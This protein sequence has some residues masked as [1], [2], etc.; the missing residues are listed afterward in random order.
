MTTITQFIRYGIVGL[1]SNGLLYLAYL[2]LTTVGMGPKLAMS[3]LYALGVAQTFFF[4]KSWTFR[5][6][7]LY[8]PTFV[9]YCS[10]Y[11]LGY[12]VN[13]LVLLVLVDIM[14]FPHQIVQ[15]VMI[16]LLAAMLFTLHK[17]WVFRADPA[18]LN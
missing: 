7:G 11:G 12:L 17:F 18:S 10:S 3:L 4:N 9:R 15:G 16:L 2:L 5:H 1:L 6:R 14:S 8:G 13:L